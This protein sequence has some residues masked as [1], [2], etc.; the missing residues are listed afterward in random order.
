ML[1]NCKITSQVR[2]IDIVPTILDLL[3]IDIDT[4]YLSFQGESLS[5]II[6]YYQKSNLYKFLIGKPK[7]RIA[8]VETGGLGGPWPSPNKPNVVCVRT[9]SYKLIHNKTPNTWEFYD[10]ISDPHEAK[11]LI[12]KNS[13]HKKLL[14]KELNKHA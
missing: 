7:D 10:L 9:P 14:K 13:K 3:K 1:P 8:Y 4:S 2:C 6:S 12:N 5:S 11:N